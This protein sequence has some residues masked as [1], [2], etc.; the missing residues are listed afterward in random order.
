MFRKIISLFACLALI[1]GTHQPVTAQEFSISQLPSPG[2]M[3]DVSAPFVPLAL[4]GLV[5][6]P[7]QPLE[8][9]FIVDTGD[10]EQ[11]IDKRP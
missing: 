1:A 11:T 4:K 7:H 8:F 10:F 9:Q 5:L 6:N 2:A 3:V